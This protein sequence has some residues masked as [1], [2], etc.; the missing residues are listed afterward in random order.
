MACFI[1]RPA[2]YRSFA[3]SAAVITRWRTQKSGAISRPASDND[4]SSV[5]TG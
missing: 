3:A 2:I 4:Y 5:L 1:R